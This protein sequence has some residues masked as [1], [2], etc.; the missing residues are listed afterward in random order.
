MRR[1]YTRKGDR[2]KNASKGLEMSQ[3]GKKFEIATA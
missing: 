2:W 1:C 3:Y